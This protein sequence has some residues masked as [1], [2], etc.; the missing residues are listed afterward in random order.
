M[1]ILYLAKNLIF[2]V[3]QLPINV[4]NQEFFQKEFFVE[5]KKKKIEIHARSIFLQ[6]LLIENTKNFPIIYLN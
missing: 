6:G 5:L 4:L 3:I 1:T 2:D